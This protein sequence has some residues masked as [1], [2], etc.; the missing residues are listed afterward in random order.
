[1]NKYEILKSMID[2]G[3]Q[4]VVFTGAGISVASGIPDFR[5]E[6]GVFTS[7]KKDEFNPEEVLSHSYFT[8]HTKEFFDFYRRKMLY[9]NAKPSLAHK[10]FAELEKK[11]KKVVVVTQNIDGLHQAASSSLVYELHGNVHR[12]YCEKCNRLFGIKYILDSKEI[13]VCDKCGG[14][15]KPDVVLYEEPLNEDIITRT[16]SA[17]MTCDVLVV[18]GTSLIVY[19]AAGFLRYFRGK[20]LIVINKTE[21]PYDNMCDLVIN[22]DVESVIKKII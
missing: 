6:K 3:N 21:T 13:P 16:I 9:E 20:Y 22:E 5:G 15:I 14:V 11:G 7:T 10:Y 8:S 18:V 4:I 12:N 19:P 2:E 17:I 1:M